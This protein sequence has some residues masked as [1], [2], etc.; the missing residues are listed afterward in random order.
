MVGTEGYR[1]LLPTSFADIDELAAEMGKEAFRA[2][3][4]RVYAAI[5]RHPPYVPLDIEARSTPQTRK[6]FVS[7]LWMFIAEG[8]GAYFDNEIKHF[9]RYDDTSLARVRREILER[10]YRRAAD[11]RA[12]AKIKTQRDCHTPQ[13]TPHAVD[14]KD[15]RA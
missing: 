11:E 7:V 15:G 3:V 10:K 2:Y 5:L 8:N 13:N 1:Q 9:V 4:D 14:T 12:R 6:R